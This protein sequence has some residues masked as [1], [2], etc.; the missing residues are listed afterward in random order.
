MTRLCQG[1]QNSGAKLAQALRNDSYR[2]IGCRKSD[3]MRHPYLAYLNGFTLVLA[4][5]MPCQNLRATPASAQNLTTLR[6]QAE[7]WLLAQMT[8]TSDQKTV[9]RAGELDSRVQLSACSKPLA[10]GFPPGQST[11]TKTHVAV[12]CR[13]KPSWRLFLPM[14]I[15]R[16][17]WVWV[18]N[19]TITAA[20]PFNAAHWQRQHR[21]VASLP[22]SAFDKDN[23]TAYEARMTLA[24]G[25]VLCENVVRA[26][27][28]VERGRSLNLTANQGSIQIRVVVEALDKGGIGQRIRVRNNS[29]GRIIDATIVSE[30]EA[31]IVL[32]NTP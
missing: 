18:A 28:I 24:T 12:S 6:E 26:K 23:V 31:Q 7:Q 4:I 25:T 10:F 19:R 21:D 22:C 13:D 1:C 2:L 17:Q 32:A 11:Q 3:A 9:V 27:T 16:Q 5:L 14:S 8:H 30:S 15:S 20:T 29:T